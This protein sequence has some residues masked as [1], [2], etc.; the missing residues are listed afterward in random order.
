MLPLIMLLVTV[1]VLLL[2]GRAIL[3][4]SNEA[5]QR[6]A[7]KRESVSENHGAQPS[8]RTATAELLET[9]ALIALSGFDWS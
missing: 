5:L 9:L 3:G 2:L 4:R 8:D 7:E 1:A 6:H